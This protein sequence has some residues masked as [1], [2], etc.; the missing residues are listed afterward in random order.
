[1]SSD[2]HDRGPR[3]EPKHSEG[4][5]S[6]VVEAVEEDGPDG[7]RDPLLE[8]R[9]ACVERGHREGVQRH[10]EVG[11]EEHRPAERR[12]VAREHARRP[13]MQWDGRV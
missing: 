5:L 9:A 7:Q 12:E 8:E 1:M 3:R 4:A 6:L 10:V 11:A 13:A 2:R